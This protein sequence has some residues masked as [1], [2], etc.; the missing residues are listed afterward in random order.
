MCGRA[1]CREHVEE[2]GPASDLRELT[3]PLPSHEQPVSPDGPAS[4]CS[5]ESFIL[6]SVW[7]DS[8]VARCIP[9]FPLGSE[10]GSPLLLTPM[11]PSSHPAPRCSVLRLGDSVVSGGGVEEE[12]SGSLPCGPCGV[13]SQYAFWVPAGVRISR[14]GT[15]Q[16]LGGRVLTHPLGSGLWLMP[17]YS[18]KRALRLDLA[19]L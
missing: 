17:S 15:G 12:E 9:T 3:A 1:V 14:S 8:L 7:F 11:C 6:Q 19:S 5:G 18:L 16:L 13:L 2:L 10:L 4:L